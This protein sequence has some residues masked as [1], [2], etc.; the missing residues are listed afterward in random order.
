MAKST[1]YNP[2]SWGRTDPEIITKEVK[3][4]LK[5][6]VATPYS[7]YLKTQIG[8][9]VPRYE[10]FK[11]WETEAYESF[12]GMDPEEWFQ[13]AVADPATKEFKEEMFPLI[14]EGY[15]G[16]LRGSGRF[17]AEEAGISKFSE[18]LTGERYKAMRDIPKEQYA[19]ASHRYQAEYTDWLKSLPQYNPV[20][21]QVATFLSKQT[22]TGTTVLA[23]MDPG[24]EGWF[25]DFLGMV[26]QAAGTFAIAGA[27]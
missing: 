4:P 27:L 17:K 3:D 25:A 2:F 22:S 19:M 12:A 26:M 10:G 24:Q 15:A 20:L 8:K 5:E 16:S 21:Q 1:W 11:P 23:G 18:Y 9:G 14:T 7:E 13:G 6:A